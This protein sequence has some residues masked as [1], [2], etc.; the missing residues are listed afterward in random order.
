MPLH[1]CAPHQQLPPVSNPIGESLGVSRP[2]YAGRVNAE[3]EASARCAAQHELPPRSS[4]STEYRLMFHRIDER[5][6]R[7]RLGNGG[8]ERQPP[9]HHIAGETDNKSACRSD[10]RQ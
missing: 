4:S 10:T 6:K 5:Q 2:P 9:S 7:R 3:G 8:I 1:K